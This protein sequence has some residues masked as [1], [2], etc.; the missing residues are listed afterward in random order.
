MG[1]DAVIEAAFRR[2]GILR[3]RSI[4][5]LFNMAELLTRQAVTQGPRLMIITNAGGPGVIATD[6]LVGSGG[7]ISGLSPESLQALNELLPPH[8]SHGNPIDILGDADPERYAQATKLALQDPQCDGLL[9]ILTPQAMSDPTQTAQ[10]LAEIAKESHKPLLA[11]WLGGASVMAGR[12]ILSHA[13]IAEF[14]Y[15]DAAAQG[16]SLSLEIQQQYLSAL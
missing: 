9:V 4:E 12:S 11:S 6:A 16:L 1:S 2:C 15:P 7:H 8:W 3:V 13:G 5:G 14:S 10:R